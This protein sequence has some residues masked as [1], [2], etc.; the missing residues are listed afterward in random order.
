MSTKVYSANEIKAALGGIPIESGRGDDE[1]VAIKAN[2][3]RFSLKVGSDGEATYSENRDNSHEVTITL[4]QTSEAN[5]VFSALLTGDIKTPGGAG[6]VPFALKDMQGR[7]VF[8]EKEARIAGWPDMSY[9]KETGTIPWIL[10]CPNPERFIG[11]H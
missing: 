10:L 3:P 9:A 11:G 8:F 4:M 6:I 1:F 5:A 2:N 7:D